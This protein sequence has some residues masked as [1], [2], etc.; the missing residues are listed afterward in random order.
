MEIRAEVFNE[1]F[2]VSKLTLGFDVIVILVSS[3]N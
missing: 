3:Q 1:V 2:S